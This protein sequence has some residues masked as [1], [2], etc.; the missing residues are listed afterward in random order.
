MTN[1]E[2]GCPV[3]YG[4]RTCQPFQLGIEGARCRL[5]ANHAGEHVTS[6]VKEFGDT[7]ERDVIEDFTF[8][9]AE[10]P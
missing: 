3:T 10:S 9:E 2:H 6:I 5:P 4:R 7:P 1:G 8:V